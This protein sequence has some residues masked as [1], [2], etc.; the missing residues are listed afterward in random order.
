MELRLSVLWLVVTLIIIWS[1][2]CA[3]TA[4]LLKDINAAISASVCVEA[5]AKLEDGVWGLDFD[6]S[7][8]LDAKIL[9]LPTPAFCLELEEGAEG[10]MGPDGELMLD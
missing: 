8:C 6:A 9:G 7:A 10:F 4:D 3:G 5:G 1:T 2:G